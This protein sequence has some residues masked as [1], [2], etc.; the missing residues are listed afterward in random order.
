MFT[1]EENEA[2]WA[3]WLLSD[4]VLKDE[5]YIVITAYKFTISEIVMYVLSLHT[6]STG[7]NKTSWHELYSIGKYLKKLEHVF[8]GK[9][10]VISLLIVQ[11]AVSFIHELHSLAD[12]GSIYSSAHFQVLYILYSNWVQ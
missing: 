6:E 12:H 4:L 3:F 9:D 2:T 1:H 10:T 8:K 7:C 11:M 5:W